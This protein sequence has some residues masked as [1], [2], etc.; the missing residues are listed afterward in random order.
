MNAESAKVRISFDGRRD[1]PS[2]PLKIRLIIGMIF[3]VGVF[4]VFLH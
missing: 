3:I 1:L 2:V 4:L